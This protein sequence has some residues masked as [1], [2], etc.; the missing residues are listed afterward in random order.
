MSIIQLPISKISYG[1]EQNNIPSTS[2]FEDIVESIRLNG[3]QRSVTVFMLNRKYELVNGYVTIIACKMLNIKT[4][5]AFVIDY[6]NNSRVNTIR[7]RIASVKTVYDKITAFKDLTRITTTN[8]NVIIHI[9]DLHPQTFDDLFE[10]SKLSQEALDMLK[11]SEVANFFN[12]TNLLTLVRKVPTNLQPKA[13]V[14]LS[15][16]ARNLGK[17]KV[18]TI[19][20]NLPCPFSM[21]ALDEKDDIDE[22]KEHAIV[23]HGVINRERQTQKEHS[24]VLRSFINRKRQAQ[25]V[26]LEQECTIARM[27]IEQ[28]Q[29]NDMANI[30]QHISGDKYI[31]NFHLKQQARFLKENGVVE[32]IDK[33]FHTTASEMFRGESYIRKPGTTNVVHVIPDDL[34]EEEYNDIEQF[35]QDRLYCPPEECA[36]CYICMTAD[37][38]NVVN[39]KMCK[40][41]V[42][43][44]CICKLGRRGILSCPFCRGVFM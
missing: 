10:I 4:V 32:C 40:T 28:E 23:L 21:E 37:A 8:K 33:L 42:C 18:V 3:V 24:I 9:A 26:I 38:R 16:I 14:R 7:G 11:I 29:S 20:N 17:D 35:I 2:F 6:S 15:L 22:Q 19:L 1:D 39:C 5:P 36:D 12:I 34:T 44:N 43:P 41:P 31:W 25:R 30:I 27:V 13:M